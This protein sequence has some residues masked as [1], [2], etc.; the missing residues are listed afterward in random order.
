MDGVRQPAHRDPA[1]R[2]PL[3]ILVLYDHTRPLGGPA[4]G[5]L[6]ALGALSR[7][8]FYF[9]PAARPA[10]LT[11]PM[12]LFDAIALHDFVSSGRRGTLA[13]AF[14]EALSRYAGPKALFLPSGLVAETADEIARLGIDVIFTRT[15]TSHEPCR[16]AHLGRTDLIALQPDAALVVLV[17]AV[18]AALERR[19]GPPRGRRFL[20]RVLGLSAETAGMRSIEPSTVFSLPVQVHKLPPPPAASAPE[21]PGLCQGRLTLLHEVPISEED[22]AGSALFFTPYNGNRLAL[23][24]DGAWKIYSFH[25]LY[26]SLQATRPRTNY[27]VFVSYCPTKNALDL[28]LTAWTDDVRRA[29]ELTAQD[30]VLVRAGS[31]GQR[32]V[33]TVRG[34]IPGCVEDTYARRFLWNHSHRVVKHL[35]ANEMTCHEYHGGPRLWNADVEYHCEFVLGQPQVVGIE[36]GAFIRSVETGCSARVH[37]ALDGNPEVRSELGGSAATGLPHFLGVSTGGRAV[38]PAGAHRI[39]AGQEGSG[40]F[41]N[42]WLRGN[43]M[44]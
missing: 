32:Y 29:V 2:H 39:G 11:F 9:A 35:F 21:L 7:H 28:E 26:H 10:S 44:C 33:G 5:L 22:S 1:A 14:A 15:V 24:D 38:L 6:A 8:A 17:R 43:L 23:Y 41:A 16:G 12:E 30:G 36:V 13:P 20:T 40:L 19:A 18:E 31:P 42:V 4:H 27:D 34:S 3:N 25:E 37:A